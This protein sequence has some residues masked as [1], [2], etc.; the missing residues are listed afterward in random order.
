MK[1]KNKETGEIA[2]LT[3]SNNG[4]SLLL[5]ADGEMLVRDVKLSDLEEWEDYK[6]PKKSLCK[7][8]YYID[9]ACK[10]GID[11]SQIFNCEHCEKIDEFNKSIG[12]YFDTKKEAER[13]VE[14]LKAW[15][16]LKDKGFRFVKWK[17]G[18]KK[19]WA[20]F[21][22]DKEAWATEVEPELDLLFGGDNE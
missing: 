11:K 9:S 5:M 20:G 8:Y 13:A 12:N 4:E 15:K 2:T 16:R 14:K 10:G 17:I 22:F 7:Y 19:L 1:L 3:M 21:E 18:N 6:K